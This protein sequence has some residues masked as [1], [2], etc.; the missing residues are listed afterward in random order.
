M[1]EDLARLSTD[2]SISSNLNHKP[3]RPEKPAHSKQAAVHVLER[4]FV[5][6]LP[7][8]VI[9]LEYDQDSYYLGVVVNFCSGWSSEILLNVLSEP[10]LRRDTP[11]QRDL[12]VEIGMR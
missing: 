11:G 5:Q 12:G 8:E 10:Y 4:Q 7:G 9:W 1:I 2:T 3:F 6:R